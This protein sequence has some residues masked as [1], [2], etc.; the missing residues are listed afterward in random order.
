V[1]Q[2][3]GNATAADKAPSRHER[4]AAPAAGLDDTFRA[5]TE[6]A[7]RLPPNHPPISARSSA[8]GEPVPSSDDAP[9]LTWKAPPGWV[10]A[11]SRSTMR[12]ATYRPPATSPEGA[13]T[14]LTVSRAG[15]STEANIDRWAGQF[16]SPSHDV[17]ATRTVDGFHVT[18]LMV[19]GTYQG[20]MG[21]TGTLGSRPD[22]ALLGAVV[23]T[24]GLPYFF[25][26]VGPAPVVRAAQPAFELLLASI[27]RAGA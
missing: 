14:E 27:R 17:R 5:D 3:S 10:V 4:E 15:G 18:T 24:R 8:E 20:G 22:W 7:P 6:D 13:S 9:L 23:E 21:A 2:P 25:K 19:E 12:L 11:P 26:L 1:F 16:D